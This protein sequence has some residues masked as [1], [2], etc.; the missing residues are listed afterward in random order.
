MVVSQLLTLND[1]VEVR[2]HQVGHQVPVS[3]TQQDQ[4]HPSV[5]TQ[6]HAR[7]DRRLDW[8]GGVCSSAC[9]D[10]KS[11]DIINK[12]VLDSFLESPEMSQSFSGTFWRFEKPSRVWLLAPR[13]AAGIWC[14]RTLEPSA[15]WT[16]DPISSDPVIYPLLDRLT[17]K[18]RVMWVLVI[19][20]LRSS[21]P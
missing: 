19:Q 6:I 9:Q 4:S 10:Y 14:V 17:G 18:S 8:W 12:N 1:V 20:A 5:E 21:L 13:S 11:N 2:P 16:S 15:N 7:A 3:Q